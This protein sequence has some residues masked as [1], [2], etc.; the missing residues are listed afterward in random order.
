MVTIA[1]FTCKYH[2]TLKSGI[3]EATAWVDLITHQY[4][5]VMAWKS[6]LQNL[7]S[8]YL[9]SHMHSVTL[10]MLVGWN[11]SK[12]YLMIVAVP[13]H[14]M[15]LLG[16]DSGTLD[17]ILWIP[18]WNSNKIKKFLY[19]NG[20]NCGKTFPQYIKNSQ[21]LHYLPTLIYMFT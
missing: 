7:E 21:M 1:N 2:E 4:C 13:D 20:K 16:L 18:G 8:C 14:S 12:N 19:K 9:S 11:L 15:G 3:V 10:L 5:L 6:P 17:K